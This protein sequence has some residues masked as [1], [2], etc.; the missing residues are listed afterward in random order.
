MI[1]LHRRNCPEAIRIAS[2]QGST[3]VSVND[4]EPN[5]AIVYPVTIQV[6]AMDRYHLLRD[7]IHCVVEDYKVSIKSLTT[8]KI[9]EIFTCELELEVHSVTEL[10]KLAV[11]LDS[12]AGVE[13]V[14][15]QLK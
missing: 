1:S 7:I 11:A 4:F 6:T 9:D 2:G 10:N 15:K 12:I 5:E 3:I 13:E 8:T 14:R